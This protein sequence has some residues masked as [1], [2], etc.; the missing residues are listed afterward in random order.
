[1][2]TQPQS[3]IWN[4]GEKRPRAGLR[5]PAFLVLQGIILAL[6]SASLG[7]LLLS[8]TNPGASQ[9]ALSPATDAVDVRLISALTTLLAALLS[10]WIA[11]RFVD[12]RPFTAYGVAFTSNWLRGWVF[13]FLAGGLVISG[14][15]LVQWALGWVEIT[16]VF[17]ADAASLLAVF[18]PILFFAFA[19]FAED[20]IY[21]GYL[22][23]NLSEGL[24]FS[25]LG[26]RVPVLLSLVAV[27][28][29]FAL[30]HAL[31]PDASVISTL[32]ITVAGVMLALG[33]VL[34]G[35]LAITVGLH[36]SWNLFQGYV[37]G[38][39]V[40]GLDPT[41]ATLISVEQV[42]PPIWDGGSFGPEAGIIGLL[43][44]LTVCGLILLR[45]WIRGEASISPAIS[46]Y[47]ARTRDSS[48]SG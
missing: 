42:G 34:T 48:Y 31:N 6:A 10:V 35:Q 39:P 18:G 26:R 12:R 30:G 24:A 41:G 46:E 22:L 21:W 27:S 45:A 28:S 17:E 37:F 38:F 15:F 23:K 11:G 47:R 8:L 14:V 32:N 40:S 3:P 13:G 19:A 33:Y 1:M 36:F 29:F 16:G 43:A 25:K 44:M 5:I 7:A 9:T 2:R 20:L 4:D